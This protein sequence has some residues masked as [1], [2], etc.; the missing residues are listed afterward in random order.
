MHARRN[1]RNLGKF[2]GDYVLYS[3]IDQEMMPINQYMTWKVKDL[4]FRR[5]GDVRSLKVNLVY[6]GKQR[7][8]IRDIRRFSLFE[9]TELK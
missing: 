8:F 3:S 2:K 9:I 4:Y 6:G 5:N 7:E 1:M